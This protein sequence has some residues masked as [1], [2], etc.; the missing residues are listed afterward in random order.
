MNQ[1]R[2]NEIIERKSAIATEIDSADEA[3]MAE[4]ETEVAE[5]E[6]EEREL[7][8]KL[9][10]RSRVGQVVEKPQE[11]EMENKTEER[12]KKFADTN[13]MEVNARSLL[14]TTTGIAKATELADGINDKYGVEVSSIVDMV[15]VTDCTGMGTYRVPYVSAGFDAAAKTDGTAVTA[16]DVTFSYVDLTPNAFSTL[17]YVS[18]MLKKQTPLM[19]EAK[20]MAAARTAL[21]KKASKSI[22]DAIYASS[23]VTTKEYTKDATNGVKIGE[24]TLRDIAFAHGGNEGVGGGVL[25]LNKTDL[26]AFGD[27]RGTNEKK[28]V[29]EITPDAGNENTGTIKDGGLTVR[30]VINSNCTAFHGNKSAT[31]KTMIYGN[32]R[33][34]E[35]AVWGD[36]EISTSTDYKFA[37]GLLS[38]LGEATLD[39]DVVVKNGFTIVTI[40][41]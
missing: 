13:K 26:V 19:Y 18:K 7:Q 3:R 23:L 28:A 16:T 37:E 9:D 20:T 38:V 33:N 12:A 15:T 22:V 14:T 6:K 40:G 8:Q 27:A 2:L 1:K 34:V 31:Q 41:A 25:L 10:L 29:Y 36:V 24:K 5:L 32:P 4:L 30:Y 35:M 17:S 39:A 21:R 11:R